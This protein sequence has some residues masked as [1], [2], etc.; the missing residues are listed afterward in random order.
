VVDIFAV[1]AVIAVVAILSDNC[2]RP[3]ALGFGSP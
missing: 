2:T 1:V 3:P